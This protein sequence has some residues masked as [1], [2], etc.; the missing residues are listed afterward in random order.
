MGSESVICCFNLHIKSNARQDI[1]HITEA[2]FKS[3]FFAIISEILWEKLKYAN[4]H[5]AALWLLQS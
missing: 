1:F 4:I 5:S 2:L 3:I